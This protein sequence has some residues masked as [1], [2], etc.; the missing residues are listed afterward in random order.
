M[1][2]RD[3]R[4][5]DFETI[6]EIDRQCFPKGIAYSR[7]EIA[8]TVKHPGVIVVVAEE[9]SAV[10]GFVMAAPM[11]KGRGHIITIDVLAAHRKRGL[12]TQ[13]ME[14]THRRLLA[15]GK[16]RVTLE[17]AV[18]NIAAIEFYQKLGYTTVRRL[19]GYYLKRIDAWHMAKEL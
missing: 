10:A 3:Y 7:G 1:I 5:E 19:E 14:E 4:A 11:E 13:L 18:D 8:A 9:Q 17:T 6:C 2:L 15:A 12:G 16:H